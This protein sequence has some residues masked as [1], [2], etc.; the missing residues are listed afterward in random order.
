MILICLVIVPQTTYHGS[1]NR[2]S[3]YQKLDPKTVS[4]CV[5]HSAV[6]EM[7]CICSIKD[8][9]IM[10]KCKIWT[11]EN[12]YRTLHRFC[13]SSWLL[14]DKFGTRSHTSYGLIGKEIY[15]G[16]AVVVILLSRMEVNYC[17]SGFLHCQAH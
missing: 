1:K 2:Q 15:R 3:K 17:T 6:R 14:H 16:S 8:E 11:A 7:V 4:L 9:K 13:T 10:W 12:V 5:I